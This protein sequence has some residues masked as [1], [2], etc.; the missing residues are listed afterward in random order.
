MAK[1]KKTVSFL[2]TWTYT[3][4][5]RLI[6]THGSSPR[7][8]RSMYPW[9]STPES[10]PCTFRTIKDTGGEEVRRTKK[11]GEGMPNQGVL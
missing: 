2:I 5:K 8:A 11:S 3:R 6:L 10:K 4:G 7:S 9:L 1:I